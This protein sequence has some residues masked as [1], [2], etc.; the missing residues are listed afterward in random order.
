MEESSS[1]NDFPTFKTLKKNHS[2]PLK[3]PTADLSQNLTQTYESINTT[4]DKT[5]K[6]LN[7]SITT[8]TLYSTP[9]HIDENGEESDASETE[10][11]VIA[12]NSLRKT[13]TFIQR[14]TKNI[15]PQNL[16]N[17]YGIYYS[18]DE[19]KYKIG[20]LPLTIDNNKIFVDDKIFNLTPGLADL[21]FKKK[22]D[23]KKIKV[24]DLVAY[25]KI[26][27][28]SKLLYRNY[29][30]NQQLAGS[31]SSKYKLIK[32]LLKKQESHSGS[33]IMKYSDKK[34]DYVYWDNPNELVERLKLL[35][36]SQQAGHTNHHNEIVSILE[37]LKE[38]RIIL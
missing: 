27:N 18:V 1:S 8:T 32:R 17:K 3:D 2:T 21:L 10:P 29:D 9:H 22:T 36:A 33:G 37:E 15:P 34:I 30:Q 23:I 11:Y 13:D 5:K 14:Y 24:P 28:A 35:L 19:D 7:D 26:V 12:N 4:R 38:K 31:K 6:R 20:K 16:D 25:K